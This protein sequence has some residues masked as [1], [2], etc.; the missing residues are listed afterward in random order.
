M[1]VFWLRES[2]TKP[3]QIKYLQYLLHDTNTV[4]LCD[5]S[6]HAQYKIPTK[7]EGCCS[8]H[9][10]AIER[11]AVL[12]VNKLESINQISIDIKSNWHAASD[13]LSA[14]ALCF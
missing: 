14:K 10:K 11:T 4:G 12:T 6:R 3:F 13:F 1:L 9:W 2:H 7:S 5:P 8:K